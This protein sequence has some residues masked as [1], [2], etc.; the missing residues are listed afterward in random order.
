MKL[1]FNED[2]A[3]NTEIIKITT[4]PTKKP[5]WNT[6]SNAIT[7]MSKT[8]T[9]INAQTNRNVPIVLDDIVAIESEGRMCNVQTMSGDMYLINMR[10]KIFE[11]STKEENFFRINNQVMINLN[12]VKSFQSSENARLEV[13]MQNEAIYFVNRYYVKLFKE[14]FKL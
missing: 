8:I 11:E 10:L 9:V 5:M 1:I 12:K 6:M 4:N 3:L 2:Q 7:K 14:K 13:I